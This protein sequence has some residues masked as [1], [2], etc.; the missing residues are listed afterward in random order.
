MI[1]FKN[2]LAIDLGTANF[3]VYK[4]GA[5]IVVNEP[6]VVAISVDKN[7]VVA[8][9][10]QAKEMLGRTP[11]VIT[12]SHPLKDGVIADYRTTQAMLKYYINHVLGRF[13]L[14]RPELMISVP[15]GVTS[16]EKRAVIDAALAAGAKRVYIIREPVAA[17]I[18]AQV[19]IASPVGNL[20][21]DIGGGTTEIAII[22]L[23]GIVAQSS[24][25]IGGNKIDQAIS[26][27]LRRKYN[28][29]IGDQ[30]AEQVKKEIGSAT[31]LEAK[32]TLSVRG[33]DMTAG[34]PKT[35]E[36][37]SN[38]VTEAI[39]ER[40][41]S[42]ILA[43]KKVLEATPPELSS[44]IIDRGILISGGGALL[45]NIDTLITKVTGVPAHTASD[46][47]LSVARGAG[48]ALEN[49]DDYMRSV[50]SHQ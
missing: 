39:S 17:A 6:S 18:G 7:Q 47:L 41:S 14:T 2:R 4:P 37:S 19:P 25:R 46:P 42:I 40:L 29:I 38:E 24:V 3:L 9:G 20:I 22:S 5:G 8:V 32:K 28:L 27:Y 48:I 26:D 43:I 10:M 16:T 50:I 45:R 36:I 30:T 15:A 44:D 33:R 13:R 11:E 34:L 23:G 31:I 1:S 49:L 35:V 12:A 21:V